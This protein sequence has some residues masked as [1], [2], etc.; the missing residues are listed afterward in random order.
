MSE[1]RDASGCVFIILALILSFIFGHG[2]GQDY[3]KYRAKEAGATQE[4]LEKL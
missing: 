3:I 1:D 4:V 2:C